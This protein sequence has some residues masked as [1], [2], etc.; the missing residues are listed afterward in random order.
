MVDTAMSACQ[1]I[2]PGML[3]HAEITQITDG[4]ILLSVMKH[5]KGIISLFHLPKVTTKQAEI[6]S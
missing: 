1:C 3:I 6:D 2:V 4:G 5:Y